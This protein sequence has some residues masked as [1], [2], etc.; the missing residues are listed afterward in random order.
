MSLAF[1][2]SGQVGQCRLQ[3]QAQLA[4]TGV[5]VLFGPSG[6]GDRKSVV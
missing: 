3:V 2:L 4:A 6:S 5:T 1:S